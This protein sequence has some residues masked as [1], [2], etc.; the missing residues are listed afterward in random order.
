MEEF[1]YNMIPLSYSP[2][3]VNK[4]K[5]LEE[6]HSAFEKANEAHELLAKLRELLIKY[7]KND[8]FGFSLLH[9][10]FPLELDIDCK[11]LLVE[12]DNVATP[13]ALLDLDMH[14]DIDPTKHQLDVAGYIKYK[15]GVIHPT[16]W[17]VVET[18]GSIGLMPYEF[19]FV[20][21]TSTF[22]KAITPA[23]L[24]SSD[25]IRAY[26]AL[27]K[28]LEL[29][30]VV[31]LTLL[32]DIDID[33]AVEHTVGKANILTLRGQHNVASP[34]H[35]ADEKHRHNIQASF[36]WPTN[37]DGM[38]PYKAKG[39][40]CEGWETCKATVAATGKVKDDQA[41]SRNTAGVDSMHGQISAAVY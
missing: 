37:A 24:H 25:F 14:T 9:R 23:Q 16:S 7:K 5:S 12:L 39:S 26:V 13:W 4:I 28:Q 6:S 35:P 40:D 20:P 15:N 10:H 30:D 29:Q 36:F 18:D 22:T 38:V 3:Q 32:P 21:N 1:K 11:Q 17:M 41:L 8:E 31:A 19:A 2:R 27:V 34:E 33:G